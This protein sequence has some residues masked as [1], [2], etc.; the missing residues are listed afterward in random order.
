MS[1]GF[2]HKS[3]WL[4]FQEKYGPKDQGK[5]ARNAQTKPDKP[6]QNAGVDVNVGLS[7]HAPWYCR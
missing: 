5:G 7:S 6:K 4:P 3:L 1:H 2:S